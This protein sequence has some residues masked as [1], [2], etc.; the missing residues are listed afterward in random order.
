MHIR[1]DPLLDPRVHRFLAE[2]LRD[3]HAVSP[4]ESTH[5]L[6]LE[7]LRHPDVMF[8]TAWNE[9]TL[10]GT[11]A[12][13]RLDATHAEVKSMRTAAEARGQGIAGKLLDTMI[14]EARSQGIR[15]LS[16]E[17]G[18][19]AFFEPARQLY[20]G[21]SFVFCEPF[22]DYRLDPNSVFMTRSI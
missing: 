3:M 10:L 17:T 19:M 11:G 21:R 18:S 13:K 9:D 16:L 12:L 2:H 6:D 7:G 4:P 1:R 5:A 22:G 20:L 8:W 14:D 15:R